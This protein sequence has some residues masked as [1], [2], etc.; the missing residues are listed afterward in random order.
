MTTDPDFEARCEERRE[1]LRT[2]FDERFCKAE[3]R[4]RHLQEI[5]DH[6]LASAERAL[7]LQA[8]EYERRL[9]ELNHAHARALSVQEKTLPREIFEVFLA[10]YQTFRRS[11]ESQMAADRSRSL[12][13]TAAVAVAFTI[14]S[15]ALSFLRG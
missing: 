14:L 15:I 13:W 9:D 6:R 2:L 7:A 5:I 8:V 11:V 12:T 3:Q 1:A 10:E 4:T